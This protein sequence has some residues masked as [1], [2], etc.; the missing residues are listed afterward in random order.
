MKFSLNTSPPTNQDI[1]AERA[2]IANQTQRLHLIFIVTL[3]LIPLF[4]IIGSFVLHGSRTFGTTDYLIAEVA[5]MVVAAVGQGL[6]IQGIAISI[7]GLI[8][9]LLSLYTLPLS[10]LMVPGG[11]ILQNRPKQLHQQAGELRQVSEEQEKNIVELK[12][13]SKPVGEYYSKVK[14]AKRNYFVRA[15]YHMMIVQREG[16]IQENNKKV[17]EDAEKQHG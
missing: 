16:E 9:S 5:M 14:A 1:K 11:I 4:A 2:K 13:T 12:I 3:Y 10:V 8:L 7:N 17:R 15:E 6:H